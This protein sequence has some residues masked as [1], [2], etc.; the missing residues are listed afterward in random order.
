MPY[1]SLTKSVPSIVPSSSTLGRPWPTVLGKDPPAKG[2]N[3]GKDK[4]G[5]KGKVKGK[6]KD[7]QG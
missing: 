2:K 7:K 5:D 3:K 4:G 6:G 1:A